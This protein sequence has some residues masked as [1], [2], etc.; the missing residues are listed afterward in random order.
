LTGG[1]PSLELDRVKNIIELLR[2]HHGGKYVHISILTNGNLFRKDINNI[3]YNTIGYSVNTLEDLKE[4][5][6][7]FDKNNKSTDTIM[8]TNFGTYNIFIFDKLFEVSK[9]FA[10]W[11]IQLTIGQYQLTSE[12]IQELLNKLSQINLNFF[13]TED[14]FKD[15]RICFSHNL[16]YNPCCSAGINSLSITYDYKILPCLAERT[17]NNDLKYEGDFNNLKT[18]E[19]DFLQNIWENNFKEARFGLR[20]CCCD[21]F[22]NRNIIY[23]EHLKFSGIIDKNKNSFALNEIVSGRSA[24]GVFY[25]LPINNPVFLPW[26]N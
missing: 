1:E 23:P 17:Y 8:I 11:Q 9:R 2:R 19:S 7:F 10:G 14:V 26:K 15:Y 4:M 13:E 20:K 3:N 22:D 18:P 16:Q 24:Y 25:T 6:N 5:S 21:C 12:G